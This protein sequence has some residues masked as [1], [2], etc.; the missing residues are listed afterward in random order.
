MKSQLGSL[1][2]ALANK[3]VETQRLRQA[4]GAKDRTIG[5]LQEQLARTEEEREGEA[6]RAADLQRE[7]S[8][9]QV[10][11]EESNVNIT[12]TSTVG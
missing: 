3:D 6:E 10:M 2:G 9:L 4:L 11:C 7:K 1:R 5:E 8:A 12:N